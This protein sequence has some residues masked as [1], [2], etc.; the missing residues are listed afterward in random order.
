MRWHLTVQGAPLAGSVCP[1][2]PARGWGLGGWGSGPGQYSRAVCREAHP[3]QGVQEQGGAAAF[4]FALDLGVDLGL[5]RRHLFLPADRSE[6][7]KPEAAG[8]AEAAK[9]NLKAP[10]DLSDKG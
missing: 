4:G 3:Q 2:R 9:E 10:F 8:E 1:E 5:A 6:Q 7:I